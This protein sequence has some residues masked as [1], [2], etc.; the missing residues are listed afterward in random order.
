MQIDTAAAPWQS[1]DKILV[2]SILPRPIGWISTISAAGQPNLAP[3]SF[4]NVVC[5]NPP[6]VMFAPMIRSTDGLPKDTLNNLRSVPEFVVNI[7][8]EP[9]VQ[10]LNISSTEFSPEIDEFDAAQL[11]PVPSIM[12]RPQRVAESPIN[13]ECQVA[14]IYDIGDQPGSGG[15]VIGKVVY[16]HIQDDLL[17]EGDKIDLAKLQ[18]IGRLAGNAYCRVTDILHLQRPASQI[19]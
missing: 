11:T 15:V 4:F 5:G 1:L 2:G 3:F 10:A 6:H 7:A 19:R 18:P 8:T 13:F 16:M 9:L 17:F 14:H 12:V